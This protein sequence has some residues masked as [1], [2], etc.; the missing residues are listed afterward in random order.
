MNHVLRYRNA[1]DIGAVCICYNT[2]TRNP[3]WIDRVVGM[4][5]KEKLRLE[6][7]SRDIM[8]KKCIRQCIIHFYCIIC[9]EM[10]ATE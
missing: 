2:Q 5:Y 8:K 1:N 7:Y 3:L 10:C 9:C 4:P 6:E